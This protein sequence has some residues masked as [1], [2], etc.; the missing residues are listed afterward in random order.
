MK[1]LK[2]NLT[3]ERDKG[4]DSDEAK[5]EL[6]RLSEIVHGKTENER[7]EIKRLARKAYELYG[8][9]V[10]EIEAEMRKAKNLSS[11]EL[12][13]ERGAMSRLDREKIYDMIDDPE[14]IEFRKEEKRRYKEYYIGWEAYKKKYE[15]RNEDDSDL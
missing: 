6:K 2:R 10:G 14:I 4:V 13:L 1:I 9:K 15:K 5:E 12:L 11:L 7:K 8:A 3:E